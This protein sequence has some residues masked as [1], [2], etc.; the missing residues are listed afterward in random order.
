MELYSRPL[1]SPEAPIDAQAGW[2]IQTMESHPDWTIYRDHQTGQQYL[3]IQH[4]GIVE[5]APP[6][7]E[8]E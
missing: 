5:I 1:H 8:R 7:K 6:R 3:A 4:C 2:R